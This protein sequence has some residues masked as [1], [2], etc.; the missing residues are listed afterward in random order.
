[1]S[2][3]KSAPKRNGSRLPKSAEPWARARAFIE[4]YTTLDDSQLD[5]MATVAVG[6]WTFSEAS[7]AMPATF[8]YTYVTGGKG[9]GKTVLCADVM[10]SIC[11]QHESTAMVTGASLFRLLGHLDA[12]TGEVIPTHS[13]LFVDEADA[14]FNGAKD[15][16]TRG[17][18]NV[19][20]KRGATI[21]R[22]VGKVSVRY[23]AY[24]PKIL[25]G[26]DNGH[27]P[28]TVLDRC[29]RIDVQRATAADMPEPFYSFDVE[30]EAAEISEELSQ[31]ARDNA[32]VLRDY[33]PEP[34]PGLVPRQWEISRSIIQLAKALG[35]EKRM[36]ESM[37]DLFS[38]NPERT[39]TKVL[40]YRAI[41]DL[42]EDEGLDRVTTRQVLAKLRD[43]GIPVPGNSG[44]GLASA[45]S[46]NGI[47]P[48]AVRLPIGHPGIT[49]NA[50]GNEVLVHRGFFRNQFDE[51]FVRYVLDD[52]DE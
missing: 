44:K 45:L 16:N 6:T 35:I 40:M 24:G 30:E 42:F 5:Y 36:R 2:Q 25:A 34:I 18:L 15:E 11:R 43:E 31:W 14:L 21:P 13:T 33:R 38:R 37:A 41:F 3:S 27:L 49:L 20:Y 19:G 23:D 17:V 39:E 12:D 32:M 28:E 46:D 22:V 48:S 9:S 7:P 50:E 1:M 8:P 10:G 29:V 52:D 4:R 51:A 26:I 47:T